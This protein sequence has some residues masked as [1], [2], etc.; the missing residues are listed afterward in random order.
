ME[1]LSVAVETLLRQPLRRAFDWR[2]TGLEHIPGHG[3]V[4][5]AANHVSMADPPIVASV[6][7]R[8]Q[9]RVRFMAM[10]ELFRSPVPRALFTGLGHIPVPRQT[11]A[12]RS[13]LTAA[14]TVLGLGGCV[15]IFPEGRLSRDLEPQPGQTGAARLAGWSRAPVVPIGLWGTQR[16]SAPGRPT[17]LR[18]RIPVAVA[19]GPPLTISPDEDVRE[20]TDRIMA[21]I[22][23]EVARA[24]TGYPPPR[25][26]ED[27]WW[28]RSPDTAQLRTCRRP[29]PPGD[30]AGGGG[31][32]DVP[33]GPAEPAGEPRAESGFERNGVDGTNHDGAPVGGGG[34]EVLEQ[35]LRSIPFFRNLPAGALE[36][37]AERLQPEHHP[38]GDVVFRQG[39]AAETMYLVVSGQVEVLAGAEQA[40]LA[41][42]GPGSFVGELAL[43]LGEPRSATLRVVADSWLWALRRADLDALLSDHP[44]IG[45][46]LSRELGRRL[47]ATNRQLV[48][49]PTTRFTAVLG[50]GLAELAAAVVARAETARVGVLELPGADVVGP[51]PDGVVRLDAGALDPAA[52]AGMAGQDVEGIA[53]LLIALPTAE[54]A[55]ARVALG[56]A[57]HV[58]SFRPVPGWA[59][60]TG[61]RGVV[62]RGDGS[63]GSFERIARWVT[64]QAVGLALS[65]GGSKALSHLG[66]LRVLR[67]AGIVIDAVAGTS[68]GAMV[69]AGL[70]IGLSDD[71]MLDA[72]RQLA[73]TLHFRR[74]DF[75]LLPRSA[76]FKGVKLHRQLD[77]WLGGKTFADTLIPCWVV[78]TDV[79]GGAEVVISEGPLADGV[80]ASLSIPG[81]MNPWPL[82]GRRCIDGAVVNPMPASVLR[83]AGLRLVIGSNVAGQELSSEALTDPHLLQI[84]G[85]ML[86]SMEREMIKAQLPLVD[87]HVRPKVGPASSF[88]FSRIDEFIREGERAAREALPEIKAAL[89]NAG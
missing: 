8:R 23:A 3:A 40:P 38:R 45:V 70:A 18:G 20:A 33:P 88:D 17:R 52:L 24:R 13:S 22:C 10:A 89:A 74:F 71:E 7:D 37:V 6:A 5:L 4:L 44:V 25:P 61:A 86:N 35:Q 56:L 11:D 41:A 29:A 12:A 47:V 46:E 63:P 82:G 60:P 66:V 21:A 72:V 27:D 16:I 67:E 34:A 28:V 69:A 9:R 51:L 43:L 80:R 1:P 68:G 79:A 73:A 76:L 55:L 15:G 14:L 30:A 53:Y 87:V 42:L 36:A 31:P 59:A 81:A 84:M 85:R 32:A 75:N 26:G 78:A 58:A 77:G 62:L 48:T 49:A 57:E 83:D 50:P 2:I 54:G 39:D 19:I 65:S 64:G